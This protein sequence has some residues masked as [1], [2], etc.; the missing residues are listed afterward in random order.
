M[1]SSVM[2]R[3]TP[4]PLTT[5][6]KRPVH[7][8]VY[9]TAGVKPVALGL[10]WASGSKLQPI[11]KVDLGLPIRGLRI[12]LSGRL[13]IGGADMTTG[14]PEGFLNLISRVWIQG[15]NTRVN[16]NVSLYD[17]DF[18]TQYMLQHLHQHRAGS[19]K[20]NGVSV[21]IPGTPLPAPG[22]SGY[23]NPAQGTYD[24]KIIQD[25]P[26]HHYGAPA[27][28]RAGYLVRQEEWADSMQVNIECGTQAA[29][30]ATGCLGVT[31]GGTTLAFTAFGSGAGSPTIDV[32]S[33]PVQLGALKDSVVPGVITRIQKPNNSVLVNAGTG[34]S[35]IQLQKGRTSRVYLKAGTLGGGAAAPAYA[36]LSDTNLTAV[37]LKKAGNQNVKDVIDIDAYK[38]DQAADYNR[39]PI[40][41]YTCLDFLQSGNPDSSFPAHNPNVVGTGS[42]FEVIGNCAGVANG[43]LIAVQETISQLHGG[44]LYTF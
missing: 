24:F 17:L 26:F 11:Q 35:L 16:G 40:Q 13:V 1:A 28:V 25:F 34:V 3:P 18:A 32:Y 7:S 41:G 20:I 15:N 9:K 6:Q 39:E 4:R 42:T 19:F 38:V 14:Y 36:T 23:I 2:G 31:A 30:G 21:P 27:G 5:M 37:G 8:N 33:L 10:P 43:Y 29:G 44:S 12:V 22:A